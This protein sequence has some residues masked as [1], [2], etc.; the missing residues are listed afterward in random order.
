MSG[1]HGTWPKRFRQAERAD[2]YFDEGGA[3]LYEQDAPRGE[4]L[5]VHWAMRS[6]LEAL[7]AKW[8]PGC[9]GARCVQVACWRSSAIRFRITN[10]NPIPSSMRL[11]VPGSGTAVTA[12]LP[13]VVVRPG[14]WA[15][16]NKGLHVLEPHESSANAV[17]VGRVVPGVAVRLYIPGDRMPPGA[18][19][20]ASNKSPAGSNK[21]L[22]TELPPLADV[23]KNGVTR[24][25]QVD[26]RP[27]LALKV[28]EPVT[29]VAVELSHWKD[30]V[31]FCVQRAVLVRPQALLPLKVKFDIST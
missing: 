13:I 20:S 23:S 2:G 12:T 3:R 6:A 10:T 19:S 15:T 21:V 4:I 25:P 28:N 26:P 5:A 8:F 7:G 27:P 24:R 1:L 14:P 29:Y 16:P 11:S 30:S 31:N 18:P 9:L 22:C 17:P